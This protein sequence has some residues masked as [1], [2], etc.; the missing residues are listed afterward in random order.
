MKKVQ[1]KCCI[2]K[3]LSGIKTHTKENS[4]IVVYTVNIPAFNF[5]GIKKIGSFIKKL[6]DF[7]FG[8]AHQKM[9]HFSFLQKHRIYE[10]VK[11][12]IKIEMKI[13]LLAYDLIEF[14]Y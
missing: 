10:Q 3:Q 7:P 9:R 2:Q 1:G 4:A 13:F 11:L 8:L 5:P 12:Y 14:R 6:K